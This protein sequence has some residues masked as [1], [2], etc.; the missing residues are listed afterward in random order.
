MSLIF[1]FSIIVFIVTALVIAIVWLS[2]KLEFKSAKVAVLSL[3]CFAVS[4]ASIILNMGWMRFIMIFSLIPIVYPIA[5]WY[6]NMLAAKHK[7]D[8][9]KVAV[10]NVLFIIT[11]LIFWVFLPDGGDYGPQYFMFGKIA[12]D[13]LSLIAW[14]ISAIA[15]ATHIA[16]F[17]I[18]NTLIRTANRKDN[19]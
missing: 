16:L 11:Y 13:N 18:Q 9:P 2:K 12:D 1:F 8:I 3:A 19:S 5:F 4:V 14:M 7:S 10:T 15:G 6:C 17:F